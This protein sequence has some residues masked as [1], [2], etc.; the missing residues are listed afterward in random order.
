MAVVVI[1]GASS[2][3]GEA[4][5][6]ELA[7]R[8][9][10]VVL[11]ARRV[12]RLD[13]LAAALSPA[14][15]LVVP[16]DVTVSG[17][18]EQLARLTMERF[19]AIDVWINNAGMGGGVPWYEQSPEHIGQVVGVNLTAALLGVR[20][21]LPYMRQQNRGLFINIG[22]V[23]GS[24]GTVGLYSATKFGIRGLS[25]SLRRE[26]APFGVRV[27]LV[28]PGFVRTE[29]T[30]GV[31]FPMPSPDTVAR[32]IARLIRHPRREVVVPG[33]YRVATA[34][35]RLCPALVDR[36]IARWARSRLLGR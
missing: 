25:E 10:K 19:G 29:M 7:R 34:L 24:I 22:S 36:I 32:A 23:S 6:R 30:Q 8:G 27:S 35:N 16:T 3:I 20:A 21:A 28:S 9:H 2:G 12:Q 15:V 18:L 26:L 17:D 11:A 4:T 33:Y 5:A 31:N 1:T 14:E 13:A